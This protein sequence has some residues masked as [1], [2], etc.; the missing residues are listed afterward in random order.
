MWH[1]LAAKRCNRERRGWEEIKRQRERLLGR[2][3]D[4]DHITTELLLDPAASLAR[5]VLFASEK[6]KKTKTKQKTSFRETLPTLPNRHIHSGTHGPF[7]PPH[8]CQLLGI[9]ALSL[10]W[11]RLYHKQWDEVIC[12]L[13]FGLRR[14]PQQNTDYCLSLRREGESNARIAFN[15]WG[16]EVGG[17]QIYLNRRAINQQKHGTNTIPAVLVS[18]GKLKL[19]LGIKVNRLGLEPG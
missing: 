3:C 16:G 17:H 6:A 11:E 19:R 12:G 1:W 14:L 8:S 7:Y 5:N 2:E 10:L 18:Y 4:A 13:V 9:L 15:F